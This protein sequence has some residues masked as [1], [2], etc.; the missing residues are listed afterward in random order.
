M[1]ALDEAQA[2]LLSNVKTLGVERVPV[3][4]A[5]GRVL[6]RDLHATLALPPFDHSAMDCYAIELATGGSERKIVG[7]S[8]AGGPPPEKLAPGTA[9][10]IFT[11]APTPE[12]T[13]AVVM[14]EQTRRDGDTLH[15]TGTPREG[16]HIRRRG[17]DVH[18]GALAIAQGTVLRAAHVPLLLTFGA[19]APHVI[20]KPVVTVLANGDELR[21]PQ[22]PPRPGTIVETNGPMIAAMAR[23]DGAE[24]RVL[25]IAPDQPEKLRAAIEAALHGAD[26][27]FTI[28]GVS[29]GDHD[30]VR[31]AIEA[32]GVKLDFWKVALKPGKPLAVGRRGDTHVL[33]LPGNV[34]SAAI[35]YALFGGPLIR[36]LS[37]VAHPLPRTRKAILARDLSHAPGRTELVRAT[38]DGDRV[39]PLASQASGSIVSIGWAECAILVPRESPGFPAGST[40]DVIDL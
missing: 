10:R 30:L 19:I 8:R 2:Q 29:V 35:T 14:Q 31:P 34:V 27:V 20:R 3:E 26:V 25:P 21:E 11:G 9:M 4:G 1:L 37:G 22:D 36:A 12:G 6:A 23:R 40:V 18:E 16:D 5:V 39:T 17:E 32:V 7:E 13:T 33:G 28:G 15:L 24:V 38:L